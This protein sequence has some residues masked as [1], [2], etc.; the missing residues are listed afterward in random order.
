M[1]PCTHIPAFSRHQIPTRAQGVGQIGERLP[2]PEIA[3]DVLHRPFHPPLV[4]VPVLMMMSPQ[5]L[6]F[7]LTHSICAADGSFGMAD[8]TIFPSET[9]I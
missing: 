1:V 5:W 6:P 9:H 7:E 2:G 8:K 4:L 3:P